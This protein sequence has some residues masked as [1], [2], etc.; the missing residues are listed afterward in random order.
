MGGGPE[1]GSLTCEEFINDI[2]IDTPYV[3]NKM[4]QVE[5]KVMLW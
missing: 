5:V 1:N 2:L 4:T 3:D